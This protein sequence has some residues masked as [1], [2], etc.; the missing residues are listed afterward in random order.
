MKV[1]GLDEVMALVLQRMGKPGRTSRF[2][3]MLGNGTQ[4]F[5][6]SF[7]VNAGEVTVD[8][9]TVGRMKIPLNDSTKCGRCRSRVKSIQKKGRDCSRPLLFWSELP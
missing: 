3:L 1:Y 5:V 4:L 9:P 2:E 8:D 7:K 6:R